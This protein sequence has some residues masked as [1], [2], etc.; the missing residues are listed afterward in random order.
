MHLQEI[1]NK[2]DERLEYLGIS[3]LEAESRAGRQ[4]RFGNAAGSRPAEKA[5]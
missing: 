3:A 4:M 5:E 1:V 2:I